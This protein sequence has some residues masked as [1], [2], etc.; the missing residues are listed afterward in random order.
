MSVWVTA[1]RYPHQMLQR[2]FALDGYCPIHL[3]TVKVK[4]DSSSLINIIVNIKFNLDLGEV[5]DL[6][7]IINLKLRSV[8]VIW[9]KEVK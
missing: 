9:R 7:Q 6:S 5:S 8:S 3:V 2:L 1:G 4:N